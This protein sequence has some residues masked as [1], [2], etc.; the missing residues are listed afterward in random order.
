MNQNFVLRLPGFVCVCDRL[1]DVS[2]PGLRVCAFSVMHRRRLCFA[3][4]S[5]HMIAVLP[6]W[7]SPMR[8]TDLVILVLR[9][10][11]PGDDLYILSSHFHS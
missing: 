8:S 1:F 6:S 4:R 10:P 9:V 7:F 2:E 11:F 3:A 5:Q